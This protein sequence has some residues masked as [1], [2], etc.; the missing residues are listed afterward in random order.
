MEVQEFTPGWQDLSTVVLTAVMLYVVFIA[1]VRIL[2]QRVL[3]TMSSLDV[4]VV[5]TMGAVLGRAILGVSTNLAGGIVA[6]LTL[7]A[8]QALFAQLRKWPR[9]KHFVRNRPIALV[10]DGRVLQQNLDRC[11]IEQSDLSARMRVAG[12]RS[13]DEIALMVLESTGQV[14]LVRSGAPVDRRLYADVRGVEEV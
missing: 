14:S 9:T 3:G 2:G 11:H 5:I 6:M 1:V 12:V 7:L 13:V 8:I 10:V 4:L